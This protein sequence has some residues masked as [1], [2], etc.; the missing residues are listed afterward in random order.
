MSKYQLPKGMP[1]RG[2]A[3]MLSPGSIVSDEDGALCVRFAPDASHVN[4]L[5]PQ[6]WFPPP[7][8]IPLDQ[9]SYD[10]MRERYDAYMIVTTDPSIIRT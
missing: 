6:G 2:G 1:L 3:M 8:A 5:L 4:E 7:N 9:A 10:Q